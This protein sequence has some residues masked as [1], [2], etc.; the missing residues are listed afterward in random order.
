MGDV[1]VSNQEMTDKAWQSSD[2]D[3]WSKAIPIG[4]LAGIPTALFLQIGFVET[5]RSRGESVKPSRF[6]GMA[7]PGLGFAIIRD[8]VYWAATQKQ[9][10]TPKPSLL[11]EA[12]CQFCVVGV[13]LVC[14]TLSV[15]I[16]EPKFEWPKTTRATLLMAC[17]PVALLGRMTWI[18]VYNWAYVVTQQNIGD[19]FWLQEVAGLILGS[20]AASVVA[21][22]L[23]VLKTNMLLQ[24][25]S[26]ESLSPIH[27]FR[28]IGRAIS[29]TAGVESLT[30]LPTRSP[31]AIFSSV[32]KG[33]RPH[34]IANLG[35]D[36]ACMAA[37]RTIFSFAAQSCAVSSF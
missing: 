31:V 15:K 29:R 1:K 4:I 26:S 19:K 14:D 34:T 18:P 27:F 24:Q 2:A 36:V 10:Q 21:Y 35:P 11:E 17:P 6:F 12:T 33:L 28:I 23:F 37:A 25:S 5:L 8:C 13:P 20:L 9:V 3:G 7:P 22:P 16:V 30:K 32:F